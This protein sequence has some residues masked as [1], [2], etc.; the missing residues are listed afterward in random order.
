L[1]CNYS[2]TLSLDLPFL[3]IEG[4]QRTLKKE[5]NLNDMCRRVFVYSEFITGQRYTKA[6][7]AAISR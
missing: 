4:G 3:K 6:V 1:A 5:R 2:A 7:T